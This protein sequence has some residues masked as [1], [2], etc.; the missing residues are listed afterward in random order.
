MFKFIQLTKNLFD[1][2]IS[3]LLEGKCLD[4]HNLL[5]RSILQSAVGSSS[6][7]PSGISIQP[8]VPYASSQSAI[9]SVNFTGDTTVA[10]YTTSTDIHYP[11][12]IPESSTSIS[13]GGPLMSMEDS[14][15]PPPVSVKETAPP[16]IEVRGA[17]DMMDHEPPQDCDWLLEAKVTY[18][19]TEDNIP[20]KKLYFKVIMLRF[21]DFST[22]SLNSVKRQL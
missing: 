4:L 20:D 22:S 14:S 18:P 15:V 5:V 3:T 21:K 6:G 1:H 8:Y 10:V 13:Y 16:V 17:V 9:T 11:T 19:A 7:G 12:P 2:E